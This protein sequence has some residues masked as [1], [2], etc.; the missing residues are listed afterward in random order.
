MKVCIVSNCETKPELEE[1]T[2]EGKEALE[3][4]EQGQGTS[5][6][7]DETYD[8]WIIHSWAHNYISELIDNIQSIYDELGGTF[9]VRNA[10][11]NALQDEHFAR[12]L[13]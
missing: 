9:S 3:T 5:A 11:V 8:G 10:V 2:A 4:D 13:N 12:V 1:L 6:D 7:I